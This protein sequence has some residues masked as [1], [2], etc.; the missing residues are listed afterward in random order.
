M[1][2]KVFR[3]SCWAVRQSKYLPILEFPFSSVIEAELALAIFGERGGQWRGGVE[4][5]TGESPRPDLAIADY[6]LQGST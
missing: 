4:L 5:V 2:G 3:L 6:S 1:G